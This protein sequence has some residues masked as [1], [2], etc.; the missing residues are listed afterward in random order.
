V[1]ARIVHGPAVEVPVD[2]IQHY[3]GVIRDLLACVEAGSYIEYLR[4][5]SKADLQIEIDSRVADTH[6]ELS[7]SEEFNSAI[8]ETN[9]TGF[10]I[11]EYE[12]Q[13]IYVGN[14]ECVAK[15]TFSSSGDQLEDRMHYGNVI[16][17]EAEAV[18]D[19]EGRMEYR[20]IIAEVDHGDS[21]DGPEFEEY[22][23]AGR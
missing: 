2:T 5:L 14:D 10:T 23:E 22:D 18:F 8:A 7:E 15:I 16:T 3:V 12:V 20:N 11:D 1:L 13:D 6:Q 19:M 17:G 9:A 4:G 21:D